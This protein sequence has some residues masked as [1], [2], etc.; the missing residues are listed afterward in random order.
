MAELTA[1]GLSIRKQA[2]VADDLLQS[3][4]EDVHPDITIRD[5]EMFGQQTNILALKIAEI[6]ELIETVNN[7][8]NPLKAEGTS[9]D[10]IGSFALVPRQEAKKSFTSTQH[11]TEQN[12]F[13]ISS[14]A[15]LENPSTLDRFTTTTDIEITTTNCVVVEY[16]VDSV[17]NTTQYQINI[18]SI[19]YTYTSDAD[20][21]AL[22]I[23]NGL[24]ASI[25]ATSPTSFSAT[26]DTTNNYLVI[27]AANNSPIDV[28][29]VA[30]MSPNSVTAIGYV[31]AEE[32]G[33]I[34][35]PSNAV[36]KMV[37]FSN[38]TTSN[39][40][41]YTIGREKES[42]EDYRNRI[43]TTQSSSGKATLEAIQD[44]TSLVSGVTTASVIENDSS[45]VDGAGRPANSFETIVQGGVEYDVA[46]AIMIAKPAGIPAYGN[47]TVVVVDKYGNDRTIGLTRPVSINLAF[48]VD[49]TKHPEV[50]F[51][52][53][54][55][56][57]IKEALNTAVND[58]E[59][60]Q[61]V[62]PI[63]FFGAVISAVGFLDSLVIRVQ[64]ITNQGDT[65]NPLN[66]QT[67][68]LSV[69]ESSFASTTLTDITVIEV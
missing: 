39:P 15:I 58:L 18:N 51:P 36:T 34:N 29:T 10:D 6:E 62:I 42:D 8:Q 45:V 28:S 63:T 14:G 3:Y 26:V 27:T 52:V 46:E 37:T 33:K 25:D 55:E 40:V 16:S 19:A 64:Q 59:L 60:G 4:Q 22:E 38:V 41:A 30:Y 49:Y 24:K 53:D 17:L 11:F 47:T 48:E 5:D 21:T 32:F 44:D 20:A 65:P 31:E 12:G 61:D 68:K 57:L 43:I 50:D 66:W 1:E 67:D 9:L 56:D 13:L 35:V 23:I 7:S 69:D 54:G 2:D